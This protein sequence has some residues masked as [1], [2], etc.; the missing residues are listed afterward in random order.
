MERFKKIKWSESFLGADVTVM[1]LESAKQRG[2]EPGESY[3]GKLHGK[4]DWMV[5]CPVF[6]CEIGQLAVG[7]ECYLVASQ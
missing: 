1:A 4:V 2:F 6:E 5:G 7:Y 3:K